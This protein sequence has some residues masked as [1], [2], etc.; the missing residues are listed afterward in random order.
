MNGRFAIANRF[1]PSLKPTNHFLSLKNNRELFGRTL[2]C[3][4]RH[5]YTGEFRRDFSLEGETGCPCGEPLES[6]ENILI[7][8]QRYQLYRH[9]L[10][11]VSPDI[12][13]PEI[14]GTKDG[15]AA[16]SEFLMNS[17]AFSRLGTPHT[18]PATPRFEDEPVPELDQ[19]SRSDPGD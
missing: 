2:Q 3:R 4:T 11:K 16:L 14:M 1:P 12:S 6:C 15:I 17:G 10:Q 18:N 13:L 5:G 19:D 8:C 7:N 9:T